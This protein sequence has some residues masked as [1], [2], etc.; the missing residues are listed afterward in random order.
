MRE[1]DRFRIIS[2]N[3]NYDEYRDKTWTVS[4][5]F[6]SREEHPGYDKALGEKLYEAEGLPFALYE[7]EIEK[8]Q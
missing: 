7:Y 5:V 2:D 8:E 4:G 6:Y 1:G 3:E